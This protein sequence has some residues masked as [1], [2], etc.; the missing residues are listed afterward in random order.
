MTFKELINKVSFEDLLPYLM[1]HEKEHL[2]NIYAFR[3]A[4]D[5]LRNMEPAPEYHGEIHVIW[6]AGESDDEEKYVRVCYMD[7]ADWDEDLAKEIIVDEGINPELT[8]LAMYCLWEITYWGFSP[9]ERNETW[10]RKFG[11]K[12]PTN[13]YEVALDKLEESIWRHQIPRKQRSKAPDGSRCVSIDF[14]LKRC[15]RNN[16]SKRKREYRQSKRKNYL[17]KMAKR[18]NLVQMLSAEGNSLQRSDVEFLLNIKYGC[19]YDYHSITNGTDGRLSYITE[20][21]TK[22]QQLDLSKYDSAIV[23]IKYSNLYQPDNAELEAFQQTLRNRPKFAK[24]L[25]GIATDNRNNPEVKV[26]LLLNKRD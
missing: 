23:F 18:E 19:R 7:D 5:I 14:I 4:Y 21:M 15:T 1:K 13:P 2:D 9:K 17:K 22:Y 8:K 12:K 3:E 26:T 25:F 20:S 11:P 24:I 16:R 10:E 6:V